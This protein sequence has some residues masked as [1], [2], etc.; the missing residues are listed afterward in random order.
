MMK[1]NT[2]VAV[3]GASGHI[4]NVI[5]RE[6]LQRGYQVRALCRTDTSA[7]RGIG[8]EM[9]LGDVLDTNSLDRLM[10]GCAV[11]FHCAA[12]ISVHGDP[13]GMVF[14]TN[15]QG[16]SN[17]LNAARQA[18]VRRIIHFSSVHAVEELPHSEPFDESRPY[19][20]ETDYPYDYSKARGEQLMRSFNT[21]DP[22]VIVLRPSAVIGPFDFKPSE[23]GKALL[24]FR[25]GEIPA[26]PEGG[27][28]FVDVRDVAVSAVNAVELGRSGE[29]YL[30]TGSYYTLKQFAGLVQSVTGIRTPK[31]V[32]PFVLMRLFVP[33]IALW[34]KITRTK[35]LF[36]LETIA[37]L[38]NGHPR[39]DNSKAAGV[40]GHQCRPLADSVRDFYQW[41]DTTGSPAPSFLPGIKP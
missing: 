25:K 7:I 34:G 27:Y 5:C 18:G 15:T 2:L 40:L 23:L 26:L 12:V 33:L 17:V 13:D 9:V 21:G 11:V 16:V 36:S 28:N 10:A 30:L 6:L 39:M 29:I 3:T 8:L 35:P 19:K 4:G 38:K 22:E 1:N 24:G 32:L 31:L 14:R 41:S 37:A 20:K